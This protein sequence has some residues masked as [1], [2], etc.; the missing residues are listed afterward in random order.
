MHF[1]EICFGKGKIQ[2]LENLFESEVVEFLKNYKWRG[3]VRELVNLVEYLSYIYE[4]DKL[5]LSAMHHYMFENENL[6]ERI[7]LDAQELW[8]LK[9]IEKNSQQGIG[10]IT[11]TQRAKKQFLDMGEGKIRGIL[12]K[13]EEMALIGTAEGKRGSVIR[14]KGITAL[15]YYR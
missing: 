12:K 7:I 11:L 4:G 8:V 3:N 9:E 2:G 6:D 10:R 5:G 15:D 13:L 1:T 14:E